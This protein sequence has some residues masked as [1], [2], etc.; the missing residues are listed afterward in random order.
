MVVDAGLR[1]RYANRAAA[2]ILGD[3]RYCGLGEPIVNVE[4]I[5]LLDA[6]RESR[7]FSGEAS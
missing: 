6:L 3:A 7:E 5:A 1:L 2:D 4:E